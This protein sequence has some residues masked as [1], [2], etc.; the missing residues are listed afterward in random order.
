M[1]PISEDAV[2]LPVN[3]VL[4]IICPPLIKLEAEIIEDV[5]FVAVNEAIPTIVVALPPK[6]IAVVPTVTLLFCSCAFVINPCNEEAVKLPVNPVEVKLLSAPKFTVDGRDN[7]I[8][9]ATAVVPL[10]TNISFV[11]PAIVETV[12]P[13]DIVKEAVFD[14]T[15]AVTAFPVKFRNVAVPCDVPSSAT[16]I[17]APAPPI[18]KDAVVAKDAV[19]KREPVTP[20]VTFNEPVI[21]EL[22]FAI[23]PFLAINSFAIYFPFFPIQKDV[24]TINIEKCIKMIYP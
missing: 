11:V 23:S 8:A 10:F 17:V 22:S 6:L 13:V 3:P 4:A 2:K 5:T 12:L 18:K 16:V 15:V 14:A 24:T 21:S 19:P 7:V 1:S 20:A 9:P